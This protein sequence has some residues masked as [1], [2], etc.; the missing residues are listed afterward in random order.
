MASLFGLFTA[1]PSFRRKLG[2]GASYQG[3]G[4]SYLHSRISGHRKQA[5]L[6]FAIKQ[7]KLCFSIERLEQAE[8]RS[9]IEQPAPLWERLPAAIDPAFRGLRSG[10]GFSIFQSPISVSY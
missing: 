9:A 1:E 5:K 2:S 7:E 8:Y 3:S 10:V 4:A 6:R